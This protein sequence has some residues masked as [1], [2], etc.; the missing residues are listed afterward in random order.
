MNLTIQYVVNPNFK[1]A[2]SNSNASYK[3]I[4]SSYSKIRLNENKE[5]LKPNRRR[6]VSFKVDHV[7]FKMIYCSIGKF[8]IGSDVEAHLNPKRVGWIKE[9][10]L[11]GETEVTQELFEAVMGK[12]PSHFQKINGYTDNNKRPV[13]TVTW[14]D[15]LM[16]CDMLSIRL[17]K[18]PYYNISSVEYYAFH[19]SV[20]A[21][22]PAIQKAT[23]T[24]NP[25]ANGFR[26][27]LAKEWEY[28]AKAGTNNRWSSTNEEK[29]VGEIA[30]F[31]DNSKINE[32]GQT[33]PI[34]GKIPNEWGFYDMS[35]NVWEWCWDRHVLKEE[36]DIEYRLALGGSFEDDVEITQYALA[37]PESCANKIGFRILLPAFK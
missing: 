21:P 17:G 4:Q 30:W 3:S 23:T 35:G 28:A 29:K 8:T 20:K 12:H 11:L 31:T 34:K 32:E 9:P 15:A 25:L 10:F 27:P 13:E 36:S 19:W 1:K 2:Y 5:L 37:P 18:T 6:Q 24:I 7:A 33:H 22:Y 26:L 16:F 14:Y